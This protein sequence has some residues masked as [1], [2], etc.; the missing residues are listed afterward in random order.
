MTYFDVLKIVSKKLKEIGADSRLTGTAIAD[1]FGG[2][3]K[4]LDINIYQDSRN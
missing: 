1:I 2:P 3:V 4:M